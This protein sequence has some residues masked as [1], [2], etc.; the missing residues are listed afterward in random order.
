[1][2]TLIDT[3]VP[4]AKAVLESREMQS[5]TLPVEGM[6]CASCVGR[7]ERALGSLGGVQNANVNLTTEQAS[8]DFDPAVTGAT[9]ITQAI[10]KTGFH[11]PVASLDFAIG[12]MTCASCVARVEK[13]L[14]ALP[15]VVSA[16]V[17]LATERPASPILPGPLTPPLWYAPSSRPDLKGAP[18]PGAEPKRVKWTMTGSPKHLNSCPCAET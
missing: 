9:E 3:A 7:L 5:L 13:V 17:N 15:G 12:G 6:T 8:V 14:S 1:M 16:E 4:T 11:V 18:C 2:N 10:E